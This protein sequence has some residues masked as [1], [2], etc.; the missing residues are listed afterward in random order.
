MHFI[1]S[2][3]SYVLVRVTKSSRIFEVVRDVQF[4]LSL[5]V[6][7]LSLFWLIELKTFRVQCSS[8]NLIEA[9]LSGKLEAVFTL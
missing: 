4:E 3:D 8:L 5:C 6:L 9:H 7:F 2:S 1:F